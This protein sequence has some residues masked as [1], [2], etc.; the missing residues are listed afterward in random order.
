MLVD[1]L[2]IPERLLAAVDAGKWPRD[3]QGITKLNVSAER[4]RQLAAEESAIYP[5]PPSLFRTVARIVSGPGEYFYTKFGALDQIVPELTV[6]IGDFG[7][8]ADSTILLDYRLHRLDPRV[9]RLWWP[10]DRKPNQ[11]VVM[12][13]DFAAFA[14]GLDL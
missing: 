10:G 1:G 13:K 7:I 5:Y 9:L 12:A 14:D 4:V 6:Q 3:P 8:G 2:P 11:W